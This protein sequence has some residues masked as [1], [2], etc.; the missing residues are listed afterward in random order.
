MSW[1]PVHSCLPGRIVALP[2]RPQNHGSRP[3][4]TRKT[5]RQIA[6]FRPPIPPIPAKSITCRRAQNPVVPTRSVF[7][8]DDYVLWKFNAIHPF[9]NGNGRAARA[10][11][12]FVLC[13]RSGG[14]LPGAPIVPELIRANRDEY[15]A[16]LKSGDASS[17]NG[18]KLDLSV[19][20]A[21]LARLIDQQI[22]KAEPPKPPGAASSL[23]TG[24]KPDD[25]Q[26]R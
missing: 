6:G 21:L 20:H 23:S 24:G 1:A 2:M 5:V 7:F 3:N 19:L 10:A 25:G 9:I 8:T 11:C 22:P 16:A 13:L 18:G 4:G 12:Y 17:A 26:R 15:V 14:W